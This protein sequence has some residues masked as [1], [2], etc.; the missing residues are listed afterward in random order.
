MKVRKAL[1]GILLGLGCAVAF[2][3]L[4]ALILPAI[5]NEQLHLVL[6]SF[7]LPSS[8]PLVAAM[9]TGMSFALHHGW[10]VLF[11]GLFLLLVGVALFVLFSAQESKQ[12]DDAAFYRRAEAQPLWE[13]RPESRPNPFADMAKWDSFAP[14]NPGAQEQTYA[15][16]RYRSPLLEPNRVEQP[17]VLEQTPLENERSD[18]SAFKEPHERKLA[19][20]ADADFFARPVHNPEPDSFARPAEPESALFARPV[21]EHP[22]TP[23]FNA[24]WEQ[25]S[26][27]GPDADPASRPAPTWEPALKPLARPEPP[28]APASSSE[29]MTFGRSMVRSTFP[30]PEPSAVPEAEP[31]YTPNEEEAPQPSS[32][33]RSTMG[34]HREW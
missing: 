34:R 8:H 14:L 26:Q 9:N 11:T 16:A 12:H 3:G 19:P 25:D 6:A 30:Q 2:I 32:R 13:P 4:L 28:Q 22:V 21:P 31:T 29:H 7:D 5:P 27:I 1:S 17:P 33:I 15:F 20:E 23:A 10:Q 18:A 24:P